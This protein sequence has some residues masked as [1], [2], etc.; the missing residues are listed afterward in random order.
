MRVPELI[1]EVLDALGLRRD[2]IEVGLDYQVGIGGSRLSL[3]QRQKLR[4]RARC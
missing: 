1:A 3:A 4:S 2:V